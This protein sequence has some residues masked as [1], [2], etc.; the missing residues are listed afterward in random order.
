MESSD[1]EEDTHQRLELEK[2]K[3][4]H[5]LLVVI[6]ESIRDNFKG[7]PDITVYR[8]LL[9]VLSQEKGSSEELGLALHKIRDI[10]KADDEISEAEK[11]AILLESKGIFVDRDLQDQEQAD[12]FKKKLL[13]VFEGASKEALCSLLSLN[14]ASIEF[15][16]KDKELLKA[17]GTSMKHAQLDASSAIELLHTFKVKVVGELRN[18]LEESKYDYRVVDLYLKRVLEDESNYQKLKYL[19]EFVKRLNDPGKSA[20]VG[21]VNKIEILKKVIASLVGYLKDKRTTEEEEEDEEGR[22]KYLGQYLRVL[23]SVTKLNTELLT[24]LGEVLVKTWL[25]NHTEDSKFINTVAEVFWP[26]KKQC[27]ASVYVFLLEHSSTVDHL[28]TLVQQA[29]PHRDGLA[30]PS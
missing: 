14:K 17:L 13:K 20:S 4:T 1:E 23:I 24:H 16:N 22:Y 9:R 27:P 30:L 7:K 2:R 6:F 18:Q 11:V 29:F 3:S 5:Q 10:V 19:E 26:L 8:K 28:L 21:A 12:A 25:L 15:V